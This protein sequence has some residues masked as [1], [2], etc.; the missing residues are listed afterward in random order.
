MYKWIM[1]ML[2]TGCWIGASGC[3]SVGKTNSQDDG[4]TLGLNGYRSVEIEVKVTANMSYD[5]DKFA[6]RCTELFTAEIDRGLNWNAK[7][8][9]RARVRIVIT[10]FDQP[11]GT[12]R[13][14]T[15]ASNKAYYQI[16]ASDANSNT[17]LGE[18]SGMATFGTLSNPIAGLVTGGVSGFVVNAITNKREDDAASDSMRQDFL[19]AELAR[20]VGNDLGRAKRR[21]PANGRLQPTDQPSGKLA[22]MQTK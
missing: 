17:P 8:S 4:P 20:H 11:S 15:G 18:M 10:K 3:A 22:A 2:L 14:L 13:V 16:S 1:V 5:Q 6:L 19:I 12:Q 9:P 21:T 7:S